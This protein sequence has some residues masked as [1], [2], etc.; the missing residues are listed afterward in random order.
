VT[1]AD[2]GVFLSAWV[3]SFTDGNDNSLPKSSN[4]YVRLVRTP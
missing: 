2:G 4:A 3:L 1:T